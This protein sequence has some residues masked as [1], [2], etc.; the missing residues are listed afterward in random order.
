MHIQPRQVLRSV[1]G[2]L[3]LA[4]I[5]KHKPTIIVV[6]GDGQTSIVRE[7][8]YQVFHEKLPSRRNLET[9]E[10]EL[11]IPLTVIGTTNYPG[12]AKS[13]ISTIVKTS[14]VLIKNKPYR[15]LLVIEVSKS[16]Q[17]IF[18]Y[19]VNI[20]NPVAVIDVPKNLD[21]IKKEKLSEYIIQIVNKRLL[22]K[23]K[24]DEINIQESINT[25]NLPKSKIELKAGKNNTTIVDN[26]YYYYPAPLVSALEIGNMLEGNKILFTELKTDEEYIQKNRL[27]WKIN[28]KNY[29]AKK[30]DVIL[31]R[32]NKVQGRKYVKNF[33]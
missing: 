20:L 28:P 12:N 14:A 15:H 30:S 18:K 31:L 29:T 24:I 5:K 21:L 27:N 22:K 23:L 33:T 25:L 7:A 3:T 10:A 2:K 1:L 4:T 16:N 6:T 11:S 26:T 17:E 19:W 8:I 9:P 13:W 32:L